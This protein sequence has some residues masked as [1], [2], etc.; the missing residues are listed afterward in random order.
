MMVCCTGQRCLHKAGYQPECVVWSSLDASC[1]VLDL[2]RVAFG[3]RV[4]DLCPHHT[5]VHKTKC[6]DLDFC[7]LLSSKCSEVVTLGNWL[8]SDVLVVGG[9]VPGYFAIY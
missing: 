2:I 6:H 3:R 4:L 9:F 1:D 8:G 7:L 5:I